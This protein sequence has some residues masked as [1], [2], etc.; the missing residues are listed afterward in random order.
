MCTVHEMLLFKFTEMAFMLVY[1][2]IGC[3]H[4]LGVA[5]IQGAV[6]NQD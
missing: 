6:F 1:S 5:T 2:L 4:C 3:G